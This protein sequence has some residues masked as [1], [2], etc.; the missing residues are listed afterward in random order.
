MSE[1]EAAGGVF[2][3][4]SPDEISILELAKTVLRL[5]HGDRETPA[6]GAEDE[7][8][9]LVPYDEAYEGGFRGHATSGPQP[10]P[11][12][13]CH[14]VGTSD[15]LRGHPPGCHRLS[16]REIACPCGS[17]VER[18]ADLECDEGLQGKVR[19]QAEVSPDSKPSSKGRPTS[20]PK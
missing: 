6:P 12:P 3:V 9:R 7:R 8:I 17:P 19:D 4:G 1:P 13:Q 2:N 15:S 14:R 20:G 5:V 16:L 18:S 11:Y 10:E